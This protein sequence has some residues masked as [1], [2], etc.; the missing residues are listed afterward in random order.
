[1]HVGTPL[2]SESAPIRPTFKLW[3]GNVN[4]TRSVEAKPFYKIDKS[5]SIWRPLKPEMFHFGILLWLTMWKG[6]RMFEACT[7]QI[8]EFE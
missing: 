3:M 4:T 1:M 8:L 5:V 2:I 6:A 7:D